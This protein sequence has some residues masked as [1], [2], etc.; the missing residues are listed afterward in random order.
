MATNEMLHLG[1]PQ[2]IMID[3]LPNLPIVMRQRI[4]TKASVKKHDVDLSAL[5][6]LPQ[7]LSAPIFV[8]KR[9]DNNLT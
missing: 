8:F 6:N 4:L 9:A 1:L 3:F 5:H 7:H 2:G